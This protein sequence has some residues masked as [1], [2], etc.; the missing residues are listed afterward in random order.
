MATVALAALLISS[1]NLIS[2]AASSKVGL[3]WR[4]ILGHGCPPCCRD[5][6]IADKYAIIVIVVIVVVAETNNWDLG[7]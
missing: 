5:V 7:R 6:D 2:I 4:G 3:K 1:L